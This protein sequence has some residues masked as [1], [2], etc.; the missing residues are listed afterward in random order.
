MRN[1]YK[2][3]VKVIFARISKQGIHKEQ[4]LCFLPECTLASKCII[5]NAVS[6]FPEKR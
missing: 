5:V 6:C 4:M 3:E 1:T 2:N